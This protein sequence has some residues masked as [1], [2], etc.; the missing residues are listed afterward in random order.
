MTRENLLKSP[1][2]WLTQFQ[3]D[4]FR[5]VKEYQV[6]NGL[7]KYQLENELDI[8]EYKLNQIL[9]G[10]AYLTFEEIC[11]LSIKMNKAPKLSFVDL[12]NIE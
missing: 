10:E 12:D 4:F 3:I 6:I 9:S 2:Y 8:S 7:D 11:E 5:I 1:T